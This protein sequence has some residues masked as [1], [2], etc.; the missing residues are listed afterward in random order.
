[1]RH[2][3]TGV[4]HVIRGQGAGG[5]HFVGSGHMTSGQRGRGQGGHSPLDF[6]HLLQSRITGWGVGTE[7]FSTYLLK[8][9]T[10]GHSVFSMYWLISGQA[11]G[12]GIVDFSTYLLKSGSRQGGQGPQ[13]GRG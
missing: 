9:G 2:L 12:G 1:M 6:A 5:G 4:G 13:R 11:T 7:L 3:T 8:S 10:G